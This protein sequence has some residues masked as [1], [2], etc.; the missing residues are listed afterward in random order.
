M[1]RT[2]LLLGYDLQ[3][4]PINGRLDLF[5]ISQNG[6]SCLPLHA[7]LPQ[8][9]SSLLSKNPRNYRDICAVLYKYLADFSLL[10]SVVVF[11]ALAVLD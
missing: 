7:A 2:D 3:V 11:L 1:F 10:L 6:K 9:N 8:I 4:L 5:K